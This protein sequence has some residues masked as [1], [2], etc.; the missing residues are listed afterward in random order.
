MK[1]ADGNVGDVVRGNEADAEVS[2]LDF[3]FGFGEDVAAGL[4]ALG[5]LGSEEVGDGAEVG[6][7]AGVV[8]GLGAPLRERCCGFP[9]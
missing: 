5:A 9:A 3:G 4:A 7:E 2:L 6:E 1:S 8:L